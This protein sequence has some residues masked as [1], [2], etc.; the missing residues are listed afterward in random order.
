MHFCGQ[1][2][3]AL[4][5]FIPQIQYLYFYSSITLN[6]FLLRIRAKTSS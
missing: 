5:A 2:L 3:Y 6:S 4:L 1:E